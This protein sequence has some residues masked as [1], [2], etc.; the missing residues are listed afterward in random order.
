MRF[1]N[2]RNLFVVLFSSMLVFFSS[3]AARVKE[4]IECLIH[5][6]LFPVLL[7]LK[8]AAIKVGWERLELSVLKDFGVLKS[9]KNVDIQNR[10]E[11]LV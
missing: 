4:E 9:L 11:E 2:F 6:E 5:E 8:M 1:Q 3:R 10:T 7:V